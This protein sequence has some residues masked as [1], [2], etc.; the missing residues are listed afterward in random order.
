MMM[1]EVST[2]LINLVGPRAKVLVQGHGHVSHLVKMHY[3]FKTLLPTSK[4]G[5]N[6]LII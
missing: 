4:Q 5:S 1:K 6:K 3:S 2:K